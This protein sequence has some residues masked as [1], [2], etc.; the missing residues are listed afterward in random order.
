MSSKIVVTGLG[1]IS[2]IGRNPEETLDALIN[3]KSG[4]APISILDTIQAIVRIDSV[5]FP[6]NRESIFLKYPCY[7]KMKMKIKIKNGFNETY[8]LH[9]PESSTT[10]LSARLTVSSNLPV[11]GVL[12]E[13]VAGAPLARTTV[14]T[15]LRAIKRH[16]ESLEAE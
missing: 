9:S 13:R 5:V 10:L 11:I 15:S 2:S 12:L 7:I 1:I 3:K 16:C 6:L 8:R 4:I 14:R